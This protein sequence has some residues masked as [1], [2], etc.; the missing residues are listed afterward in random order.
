MPLP[1]ETN[2]QDEESVSAFISIFEKEIEI[3]GKKETDN[4][5]KSNDGKEKLGVVIKKLVSKLRME[6]SAPVCA[7]LLKLSR[8]LDQRYNQRA[9]VERDHKR[10]ARS[11][12]FDQRT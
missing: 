5:E 10:H 2:A 3:K 8:T 1:F 4:P 12:I 11:G 9:K 7:K 6:A